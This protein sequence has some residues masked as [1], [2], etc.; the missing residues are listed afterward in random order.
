MTTI[1]MQCV[2]LGH[3]WDTLKF[4][5]TDR[6][7]PLGGLPVRWQRCNE[8]LSMRREVYTWQ[9]E[10]VSRRYIL[11]EDY[12]RSIRGLGDRSERKQV[13]RKVMLKAARK[14]MK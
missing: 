12:I 8:C 1:Y 13:T 10:L 2:D 14:E 6:K 5:R 3:S 9:G 4:E 7:S 11:M